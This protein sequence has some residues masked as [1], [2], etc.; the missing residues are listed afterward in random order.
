MDIAAARRRGEKAYV[1]GVRGREEDV[2]LAQ[3]T[4]RHESHPLLDG[5]AA[6]V[7]SR[8]RAQGYYPD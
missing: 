3:R 4:I 6:F 8:T 1:C 2:R 7:G 5:D